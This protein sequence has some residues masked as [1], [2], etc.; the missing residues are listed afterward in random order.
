MPWN[1]YDQ[2]LTRALRCPHSSL[3]V[4]VP[5]MEWNSTISHQRMTLDF[6][7]QHAAWGRPIATGLVVVSGPG[8]GYIWCSYNQLPC[9]H[10]R[11]RV[12]VT[13]ALRHAD[14]VAW[15]ALQAASHS[16]QCVRES[17]VDYGVAKCMRREWCSTISYTAAI[18]ACLRVPKHFRLV[19]QCVPWGSFKRGGME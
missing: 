3:S 1:K 5:G 4:S 18:S 6:V 8:S 14:G 17:V 9:S 15:R 12:S 7:V 2:P 19:V 13:G 11:L 10:Q 16:H